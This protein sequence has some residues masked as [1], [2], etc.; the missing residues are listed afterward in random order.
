MPVDY[1]LLKTEI[2]KPAYVGIPNT[3]AGNTTIAG[4]VNALPL[5]GLRQFSPMEA[6]VIMM[7]NGDWGWLAGVAEGWV[8]SA[9]AS[10]A[11]AVAVSTTTPWATRR[12]AK[13]IY[14]LLRTTLQIDM[15][16][17]TTVTALTNGLAVLVTANVITDASRTAIQGVPVT[18]LPGW[19]QFS[20]RALDYN[21]IAIAK[22]S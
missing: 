11:G 14:D 6:Q 20:D 15:T 22:V 7:R 18:S 12:A 9:N 1:L 10:G 19:R 5:S 13:V 3:Q 17:A 2:A 16:L 4:M 21:D 8:T